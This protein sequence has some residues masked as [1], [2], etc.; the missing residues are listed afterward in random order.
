MGKGG[1]RFW[2]F[3]RCVMVAAFEELQSRFFSRQLKVYQPLNHNQNQ[4]FNM[5]TLLHRWYSASTSTKAAQ[6]QLSLDL[7]NIME[8]KLSAIEDRHAHLQAIVNQVI[9]TF[10]L[11]FISYIFYL[12]EQIPLCQTLSWFVWKDSRTPRRKNIPPPTKSLRSSDIQL[13]WLLT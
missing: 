2:R 9:T 13:M 5:Q 3:N 12:F 6:S 10:L 4:L 11:L 8:Q 7:I 1:G